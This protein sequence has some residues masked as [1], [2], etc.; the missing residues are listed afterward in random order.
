[1]PLP[2]RR[3][4]D[5]ISWKIGRANAVLDG[6]GVGRDVDGLALISGQDLF[7]WQHF[8]DDAH[9]LSVPERSFV[10]DLLELGV[11][12]RVILLRVIGLVDVVHAAFLLQDVADRDDCGVSN[13]R[14]I[15]LLLEFRAEAF[16]I[17]VEAF[18]STLNSL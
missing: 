6:P 14:L 16:K 7:L 3:L 18:F 5:R 1:M 8:V 13:D 10:D 17:G 11:V 4:D 15:D 12:E 2:L 9:G